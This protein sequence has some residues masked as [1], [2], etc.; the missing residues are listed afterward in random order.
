MIPLLIILIF[1]FAAVIIFFIT[2]IPLISKPFQ[3]FHKKKVEEASRK[4]EDLYLNAKKKKLFYIQALS[5]VALGVCAIV[6]F[7]NP[8][9]GLI[10]AAFGFIVPSFVIKNLEQKRRAK[11]KAQLVDGLTILSSSLKAGLSLF[12]AM[13][14]VVEEMPPPIS[15]EFSGLV[16]ETKMGLTL[17][18]AFERLTKRMPLE[19]VNLIA[20]AVLI[21]YETGGNLTLIFENLTATL[22][23]KKK[24][25]EQIKTLTLQG[26]WQGVI[27]SLLPVLFA[28]FVFKT[29]PKYLELMLES[30]LGRGLLIYAVVSEV[31]GVFLIYRICKL[32]V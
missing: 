7:K 4:L 19:E 31:V 12:Q 25:L 16:K 10:G 26:R 21:A 9:L 32:E 23:E 8:I 24:I 5:P 2:V 30:Q 13:E 20:T 11:F 29:N 22:R 27:M 17:Q 18:Q 15:Q 28:G 14:V 3:E 6:I 1:V